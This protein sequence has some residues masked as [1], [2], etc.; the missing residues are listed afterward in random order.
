[1]ANECGLDLFI[2]TGNCL[3][4]EIMSMSLSYDV[5]LTYMKCMSEKL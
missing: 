2:E 5:G 1:M 4:Q 3:F